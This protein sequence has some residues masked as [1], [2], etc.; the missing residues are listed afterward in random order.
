MTRRRI[1]AGVILL[2]A[3]TVAVPLV[4]GLW[5]RVAYVQ[6]PI[7]SGPVMVIADQTVIV[8]GPG[9]DV[10]HAG[11]SI[12]RERKYPARLSDAESVVVVS[13]E[14]TVYEKR[15]AWV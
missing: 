11:D 1:I 2:A 3:V 5:R 7:S 9:R 14:L 15:H 12:P 8:M 13:R 4:P 6:L 10:F